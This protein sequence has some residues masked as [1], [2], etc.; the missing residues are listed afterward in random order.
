M[1]TGELEI[2][3]EMPF[4]FWVK[5]PE[6]R[7]VWGNRAI[8]ELAKGDSIGKT[9]SELPWAGNAEALTKVDKPVLE[10]GETR[11]LHE[12]VDDSGHGKATLNVCKFIGE[13]D[14]RRCT[15]GIS[16]IIN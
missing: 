10:T 6:G 15:F 1:Q 4:F 2:F 16:F 5:D 11:F 9:D 12:Y 3:N 13:L 8:C 14:G 7:Y